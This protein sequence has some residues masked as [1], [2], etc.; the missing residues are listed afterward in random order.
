VFGLQHTGV[1]PPI[2]GGGS[3]QA[4][5][6]PPIFSEADAPPAAGAIRYRGGQRRSA[7][8]L[9]TRGLT[10]QRPHLRMDLFDHV[11]PDIRAPAPWISTTRNPHIAASPWYA[12][13]RGRVAVIHEPGGVD[14]ND[15]F[16][17]Y[18]NPHYNEQE[19]AFSRPIP[20]NH[21]VG[22]W[23]IDRFA[24]PPEP[25]VWWVPNPSYDGP[26][27]DLVEPIL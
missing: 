25:R 2:H 20:P 8:E 6:P 23:E 10:Q 7:E 22:V 17:D 4:E 21:I 3:P 13:T 24:E 26:D 14:V 19:I 16:G 11:I 18:P 1:V 9:F 27:V 15:A 5:R 12:R